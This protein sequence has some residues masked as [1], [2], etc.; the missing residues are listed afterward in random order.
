MEDEVVK[1]NWDNE[2]EPGANAWLFCSY[3][4]LVAGFICLELALRFAVLLGI[5]SIRERRA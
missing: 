5:N 1:G 4:N 3:L 2:K